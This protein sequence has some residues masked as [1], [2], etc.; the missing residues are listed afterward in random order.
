MKNPQHTFKQMSDFDKLLWFVTD[1]NIPDKKIMVK[2]LK[3]IFEDE[4]R[5]RI[6]VVL[7][8]IEQATTEHDYGVADV[9]KEIRK[10]LNNDKK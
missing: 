4:C 3:E 2:N 8:T 10:D 9:I 1:S 6:H 5:K 7:N